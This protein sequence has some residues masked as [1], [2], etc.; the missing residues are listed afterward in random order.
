MRRIAHITAWFN[1]EQAARVRELMRHQSSAVRSAY[2]GVK[3]HGLSGNDL[4]NHV[5][6]NYMA[7]LNQRYVADACVRGAMIKPDDVVFGGK[8]AFQERTKG[9]LSKKDWLRLRNGQLWSRGDKTK[10]GNPNIRLVGEELWVNDPSGRGLWI[11][12]KVNVPKK[13]RGKIDLSCY[14][15]KIIDQGKNTFKVQMGWDE[16]PARIITSSDNGTIGV[17]ANPDGCAVVEMDASGNLLSHSYKGSQRLQHAREGKRQYDV[18]NIAK[19]VVSKAAEAGKS[20]VVENL[21][22]K[23]KGGH[24]KFKRMQHNFLHR[25]MIEAIH[26][27]AAK[28]GVEVIEVNPAFTSVLGILK[29]EDMYSLNRHTAAAMVIGRRGMG[30]RERKDFT[31][32]QGVNSGR[33][34][35]E[36]R[37]RTAY[38]SDKALSWLLE[39]NQFLK[40]GASADLTGPG[41]AP[42]S[43]PGIESESGRNEPAGESS[44]TTALGRHRKVKTDEMAVY[45][46]L[47]NLYQV[48]SGL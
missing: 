18:R 10:T 40:K 15:V 3:K 28:E 39:G 45:A 30:I 34:N 14:D 6:K 21:S 2:Q 31:V 46:D 32:E 35:L 5:K 19:E 20:L 44:C 26:S 42:G 13:W 22:L 9:T 1:D 17:D 7:L 33:W 43:R 36:G 12:G 47:R 24:K 8:K 11:K 29:F 27:R 23:K 37:N 48:S 16:E 41:L 4:K 25:Q 38:L